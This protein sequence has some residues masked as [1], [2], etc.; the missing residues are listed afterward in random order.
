MLHLLLA[1][2]AAMCVRLQQIEHIWVLH[3]LIGNSLLFGGMPCLLCAF[4]R[5]KE[6]TCTCFGP[7]RSLHYST[8][9]E[10]VTGVPRG[11]QEAIGGGIIRPACRGNV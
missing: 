3:M 2:I 4:C 9:A 8:S 5:L 10:N 7:V 1:N 11:L 6:V